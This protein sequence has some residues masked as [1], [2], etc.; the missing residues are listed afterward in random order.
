MRKDRDSY[1][2]IKG[3]MKVNCKKLMRRE[4]AQSKEGKKN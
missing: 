1:R 3:D 2:V 4:V